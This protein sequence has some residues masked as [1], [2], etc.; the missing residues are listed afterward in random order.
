M[1]TIEKERQQMV[2][3]IEHHTKII[4]FHEN[5]I[6]ERQEKIKDLHLKV[7]EVDAIIAIV[8]KNVP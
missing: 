7:I 5:L 2:K 1:T 4:N 3:E 8:K 6:A